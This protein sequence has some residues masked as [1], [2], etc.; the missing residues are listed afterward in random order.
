M[1]IAEDNKELNHIASVVITGDNII[2]ESLKYNG[3]RVITFSSIIKYDSFPLNDILNEF[4]K[5]GENLIGCPFEIEF[6][7]NINKNKKSEFCL[8]QVK[9]MP[10]DNTHYNIDILK[11]KKSENLFCYSDQ[12]LGD[13]L[14]KEIQHIVYINP[15][16]FKREKTEYIANKIDKFNQNLGI[17]NPYLLI[18]P[19]RW[20]SSDPW[21]GVPVNWEQITNAKSI[22]E[23]GIDKLSPDP[24]F[25]SHFFQNLTS[26]RIGYFTISRNKYKTS[27]DWK[28]LKNQHHLYK[29]KYVNVVQLT[30]P[31]VIKIDGING[32]GIIL[33]TE[34]QKKRIYG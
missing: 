28:W 21:L 29:S 27:I 31:V 25:G 20:G 12:V 16:T 30:N 5:E 9:P 13:G 1:D 6:A 11:N 7:V 8:L 19:G 2:R 18:G 32:S 4:I 23:I 26:L 34:Q 3:P 17:N 22:I 24:S 10:I 33:K 14:S 15:D